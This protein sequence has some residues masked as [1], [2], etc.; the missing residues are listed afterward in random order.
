MHCLPV[1]W[2]LDNVKYVCLF[3]KRNKF[4]IFHIRLLSLGE[5][6]SLVGKYFF[7]INFDLNNKVLSWNFDSMIVLWKY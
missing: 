5:I 7:F 1:F 3:K 4:S 2:C 6:S